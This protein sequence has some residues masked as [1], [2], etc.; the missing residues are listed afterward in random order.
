[1]DH[2]FHRFPHGGEGGDPGQNLVRLIADQPRLMQL[3][4]AFSDEGHGRGGLMAKMVPQFHG[5]PGPGEDDGP[6]TAD[7]AGSDDGDSGHE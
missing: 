3:W 5:K 1:M 7:E 4:Q 6:G 2:V